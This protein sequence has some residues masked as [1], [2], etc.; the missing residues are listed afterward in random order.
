[1]AWCLPEAEDGG[2]RRRKGSLSVPLSSRGKEN[3]NQIQLSKNLNHVRT[4]FHLW[5]SVHSC[6]AIVR[7]AGQ[8]LSTPLNVQHTIR[9]GDS[10]ALC[11]NAE[12]I[13][14]LQLIQFSRIFSPPY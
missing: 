12:D 14:V 8:S 3:G 13:Q 11:I 4:S 9:K 1:M 6:S 5:Q 7:G 2:G 10:T